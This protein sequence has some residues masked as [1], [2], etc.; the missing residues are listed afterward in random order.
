[1]GTVI[2]EQ[3]W[4]ATNSDLQPIYWGCLGAFRVTILYL[5]IVSVVC[6]KSYRVFKSYK[7]TED[8]GI[9]FVEN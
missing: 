1:M 7:V 8:I 6:Y 9:G 2:Y 5:D 3:Y 4:S